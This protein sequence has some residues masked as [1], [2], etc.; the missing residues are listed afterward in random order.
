[1][2]RGNAL[3]I[4]GTLAAFGLGYLAGQSTGLKYAEGVAREAMDAPGTEVA[5]TLAS[6]RA[7]RSPAD[8][9]QA[10]TETPDTT[11]SEG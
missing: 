11:G 3:I 4:L 7:Y 9:A 6:K 5:D 8:Q 10:T 1:M 2:T